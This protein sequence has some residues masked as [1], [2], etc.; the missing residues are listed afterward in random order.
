[1]DLSQVN[2]VPR[3]TADRPEAARL[4]AEDGAAVVTGV[5]PGPEAAVALA[6]ELFGAAVLAVPEAAMVRAGGVG[7]RRPDG[8]DHTTRSNAHTDGYAYGDE[9]PDHF[10]LTCDHACAEGGESILLD[11]Y[12][13]IDA[14]GADPGHAGLVDALRATPVDQT[15]QGMRTSLSTVLGRAP[16]GRQMLRRTADQHPA[17]DSADPDADAEMIRRWKAAVDAAADAVTPAERPKLSAGEAVV[18]DN[19]RMLH[20]REPYVDLER[21]MWRVWIWTDTCVGVPDGMLHSDSR[22]AHKS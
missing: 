6:H 15:E 16:S 4:V 1:M 17:P 7:D 5:D 9:L 2:V 21:L 18:V 3:R 13:L 19:Y 14:L 8:L 20:G 11:G 12:A 10:L 22:F